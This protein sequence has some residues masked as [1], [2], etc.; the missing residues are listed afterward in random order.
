MEILEQHVRATYEFGRCPGSPKCKVTAE[1][2]IGD[3]VLRARVAV[4]IL[5]DPAPNG[6]PVAT[7]DQTRKSVLKYVR[8][9]YAQA[10]MSVK[11]IGAIRTVPAPPT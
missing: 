4:H 1:V 10:S 5:I 3:S 11:I 2:G 8:Q 6:K 7:I 9:L